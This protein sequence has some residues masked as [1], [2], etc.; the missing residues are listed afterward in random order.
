MRINYKNT[1]VIASL[2]LL[3]AKMSEVV[4]T[5]GETS[6][7]NCNKNTNIENHFRRVVNHCS[8]I[9][10]HKFAVSKGFCS[11]TDSEKRIYNYKLLLNTKGAYL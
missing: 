10:I 9:L 11:L 7:E 3:A 8:P 6:L 1:R 5:I 2:L 4:L